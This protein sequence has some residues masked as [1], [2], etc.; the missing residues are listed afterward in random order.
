MVK[1]GPKP[2][3]NFINIY[4]EWYHDISQ[5][6]ARTSVLIYIHRCLGH[7]ALGMYVDKYFRSRHLS[8]T[9]RLHNNFRFCFM[10]NT[11][12]KNHTFL[13]KKKFEK[14]LNWPFYQGSILCLTWKGF[15]RTKNNLDQNLIKIYRFY[16]HDSFVL[17]LTQKQEIRCS[18]SGRYAKAS[19]PT[20]S[21][22]ISAQWSLSDACRQAMTERNV[23]HCTIPLFYKEP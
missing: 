1:R 11:S 14:C 10:Q 9:Y 15:K 13:R 21:P 18:T 4:Q 5:T 17:C 2:R 6:N 22:E 16:N 12:W 8:Y 23:A 7:T 3:F 19:H 20:I